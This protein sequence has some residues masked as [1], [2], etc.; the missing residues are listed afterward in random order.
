MQ[1]T[2]VR[3]MILSEMSEPEM[4]DGMTDEEMLKELSSMVYA[5]HSDADIIR[6]RDTLQ[7]AMEY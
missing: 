3:S 1:P 5:S 6:W 2:S 7:A 4:F